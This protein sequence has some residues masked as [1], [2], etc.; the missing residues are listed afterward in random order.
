MIKPSVPRASIHLTTKIYGVTN[1]A[2]IGVNYFP[3][4]LLKPTPRYHY[5]AHTQ[6]H[7]YSAANLSMTAGE[8]GR[9]GYNSKFPTSLLTCF[10]S[11]DS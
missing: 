1:Y 8:R 6:I 3:L 5:H 9:V 10:S 11:R 4:S 2:E 7:R